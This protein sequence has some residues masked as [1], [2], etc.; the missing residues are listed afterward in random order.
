MPPVKPAGGPVRL[1]TE[2]YEQGVQALAALL[3]YWLGRSN[4]SHDQ[5]VA[6]A[7]WGIGEAGVIDK[8]AVSRIRN[9]NQA[10][11]AGL[12]HL[13]AL[14][15]ANKAIWLWQ[16]HGER[17]AWAQLGPHSSWRIRD[18]WLEDAVWLPRVDE[19]SQ[20]LALG[21]FANVLAGYEDLPYLMTPNL[22]PGDAAKINAG[23][24]ELLERLA[25]DQGWGPK[26]AAQELIAAY[27]VQDQ[28]RQRR[29]KAVIN[30]DVQLSV[31]E[32]ET[33]LHALAEMIRVVRELKAGS[34]GPAELQAELRSAHRPRS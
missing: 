17:G 10:R 28:V 7:G 15:A 30:G 22:S 20:P 32:L 4:M 12:K 33:E 13:D 24:G 11:G 16:T 2:R 27:P 18:K 25:V 3:N 1:V 14:A 9:A 31:E 34:Y 19:T 23:L 8:A 6:I 5:L 26:T 29:L 21:D